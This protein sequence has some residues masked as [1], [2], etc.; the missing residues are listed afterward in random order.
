MPIIPKQKQATSGFAATEFIDIASLLKKALAF[1]K[2]GLLVEAEQLYR[3]ILQLQ[4]DHFDSLHLLGVVYHNRG[5]H[6]EAVRQID[7][8]LKINP[9]FAAAHN[10]CGNAFKELKQ[11][12]EALAC[13]A[14]AIALDPN[15]ADALNNRGV[16]LYERKRFEEALNAYD[17]AIRAKPDYAEAFN[18]RGNALK[19]LKRFD[20]ALKSYDRAIALK[21]NFS[22][23]FNNRG[24]ALKELQR[25]SEA[26]ESYNKAITLRPDD[27]NAFNNRGIILSELKQFDEALAS[28]DR[29]IA[30]GLN[31]ADIF[32]SRA[33]TLKDLDRF[34]EALASYDR[35]VALKS[36]DARFFNNRGVV[37]AALKRFDEAIKNYDRAIVLRPNNN[38]IF[39]NKGAALH[40]LKRFDDAVASYDLAIA[41][42]PDNA[43]AFNCRGM[44]LA[45][46]ERF[47]EAL[48][49]Y[50]Q[51]I[52]L[53]SDYAEAINNRGIVLKK[54]K[55]F[56]DALASYDRA[57]LL[58]PDFEQSYLNRGNLLNEL[59]RFDEA[60]TNYG[61]A[62]AV[63]P[64]YAEAFNN[65]AISL[66]AIQRFNEALA[67]YDRA[68]TLKPDL[69]EA[70]YS[71]AA[72]LSEM[73]RPNEAVADYERAIAIKPDYM[74][75]F[76]NLINLLLKLAR[77]HEALAVCN[78]AI[79]VKPE[80]EYLEGF[81]IHLHMCLC[82]WSNLDNDCAH[83]KSALANEVCSIQPFMLLPIAA[84]PE[85]Q[86]KCAELMISRRF[87]FTEPRQP[88]W[89]GERYSHQRIRV[90]YVS[91]DFRD[92]PVAILAA[93]LFERCDRER[94]ETIAI[95]LDAESQDHMRKRLQEAF[96]RFVDVRLKSDREIAALMRDMEI[97]I[98]VD[99]NGF[100][101]KARPG[102]FSFRPA[103]IQVNYLGYAGTLGGHYWD[104]ILADRFVI[105]DEHQDKYAEK[106]VYLPDSFMVNDDSRKIT[107][108][109]P[110]RAEAGLP[111]TGFVFCCI[112]NS[113]KITPDAY[114]IW[115]HLL[116]EVEGS[117]LWLSGMNAGAMENLR[118]EARKRG[119][120]PE[121]LIFAPR[122]Q[123]NEDH[124]ARLR[125]A[126]LF[127][128]AFYYNAHTTACDALWAG[129]PL[130]TCPG[131]TFASRV[132]GSLLNAIG[133]S[134]LIT[135]TH[136]EYAALALKLARDRD[137]LAAIQQKLAR[138]RTSYPLFNTARFTRHM[139]AAYTAM[140]ERYQR[141]EPPQSFA[142]TP[143]VDGP[144]QLMN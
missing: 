30:L 107:D 83:A 105:P 78:R 114:D 70:Y 132:A 84:E 88:L 48:A 67:S 57:I 140:W 69:A 51:A 24:G 144:L 77:Y 50:D 121:R 142:V 98:A 143:V 116:R 46:T 6:A 20:E 39:F 36:D 122:I 112:N 17:K 126:D 3:K 141:G 74:D 80:T 60:L 65:R 99:L 102:T 137:L 53:E 38:D 113:Y 71:R 63:N 55:R 92:H 10:N 15:F 106:I 101:G 120:A 27:A 42:K 91:S 26:L 14:K 28:Y 18:N 9:N 66:K 34:D 93:G 37:L 23:A 128:D 58:K 31:D 79:A 47:E 82:E 139:E 96:D 11:F 22:E 127:L 21:P 2:A 100:T 97:D 86:L 89:Q 115:M 108:R 81:R 76:N 25:V 68:I 134:E 40:E 64:D 135:Q 13:Y 1:H 119:V 32:Y 103:P 19:E 29:A 12:D 62:I 90:A 111:E 16:V 35:A 118:A 136:E 87:S 75:A 138:H 72:L 85:T 52:A 4:P 109:T 73:L 43:E 8:A 45:E 7:S 133:L 95:S 44:T 56:D 125:L 129:L 94:F 59:E 5:Q 104:Y 117:V 33:N 123:S 130:V 54:L 124:L 61:R 49:S 110:S 41:L 131:R